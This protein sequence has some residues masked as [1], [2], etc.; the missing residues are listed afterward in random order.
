MT[1]YVFLATGFEE[2]EALTPVD[3]LRRAGLEARTIS[4]T[5]S[6][7]VAGAHNIAVTADLTFEEADFSDADFLILPG[8]LPGAT[9]LYDYAPLRRMLKAHNDKGGRIAAICASPGVVLA[10]LGLL[11]GKE[12]TVYPSFDPQLIANGAT[13]K[14]LR[15]VRDGNIITGNG[16]ASAMVFGLAIVDEIAGKEVA[17]RLAAALLM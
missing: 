8:G 11:K 14:D 3:L 4:V 13:Y 15:V 5:G 2:V 6:R 1:S 7:T 17:D 12:A 10:P 9:N 16:P